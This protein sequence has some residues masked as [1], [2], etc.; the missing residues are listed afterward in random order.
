MDRKIKDFINHLYDI[1][2]INSMT[3]KDII[4]IYNK[5]KLLNPDASFINSAVSLQVASVRSSEVNNTLKDLMQIILNEYLGKQDTAALQTIAFD[6]VSKYGERTFIERSKGAKKHFQYYLRNRLKKMSYYLGKWRTNMNKK[7]KTQDFKLELTSEARKEQ[8]SLMSCTFKPQIN[9]TSRSFTKLKINPSNN[10]SGMDPFT[11]LY[12]DHIKIKTKREIMREEMDKRRSELMRSTPEILSSNLNLSVQQSN[13]LFSKS[14]FER[15]EE[16]QS[17][18]SK[19]KDRILKKNEESDS[20]LFTFT[21]AINQSKFEIPYPA[22]ERLYRYNIIL[23]NIIVIL[24][25]GL[26]TVTQDRRIIMRI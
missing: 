10:S 12:T 4:N 21:P 15:Q 24:K 25:G 16:Y 2:L 6:V 14:F 1:G 20:N 26:K 8:D 5:H 22:H 11:R 3:A 17:M 13:Y 18:K 19:N 7:W 9:R 23:N